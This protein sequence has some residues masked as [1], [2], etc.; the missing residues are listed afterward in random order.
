MRGV[1]IEA[2]MIEFRSRGYSATGVQAITDRAGAPRG[3]FYGHFDSKE[4]FALEVLDHYEQWYIA[5]T[6]RPDLRGLDRLRFEFGLLFA[7]AGETG[8]E[9]GCLWGMFGAEVRSVSPTVGEV[10]EDALD[11]WAQ[12][13]GSYLA[14]AYAD[15]G[16]EAPDTI[17]LA[18][19]LVA[20]WEGALWRFRL[21]GDTAALSM[22]TELT[23]EPVLAGAAPQGN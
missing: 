4:A 2:G 23:L 11:R 3:S 21:S 17:A 12:R 10:V 13:L 8:L 7:V 16:R 14:D 19:H 20:A 5:A 9:L 1:L 18:H 22:F 6:D 15:V